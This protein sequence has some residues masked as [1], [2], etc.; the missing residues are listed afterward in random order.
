MSEPIQ[1]GV[2]EDAGIVLVELANL[3]G[4]VPARHRLELL[5]H[6]ARV[7]AEVFARAN[8]IVLVQ[9]AIRAGVRAR[10][11]EPAAAADPTPDAHPRLL[12]LERLLLHSL[13]HRRQLVL[14]LRVVVPKSNGWELT[15]FVRHRGAAL[16]AFAVTFA[17]FAAAHHR[18]E[19]E[20]ILQVAET[21]VVEILAKIGKIFVAREFE[22][23]HLLDHLLE[24]R[25][26]DARA[27]GA[28]L[29]RHHRVRDGC[30][31]SRRTP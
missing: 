12:L 29:S 9:V 18:L 21:A 24:L 20:I 16:A 1:L 22:L 5:V 28:R 27:R 19:D 14:H 4:I 31:P 8:P 13:L 7:R 10:V 6:V 15:L 3:V 26:G 30:R 25:R 2:S 11:A 23:L 17:V